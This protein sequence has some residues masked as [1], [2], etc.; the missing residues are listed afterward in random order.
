M[1]S[2]V[3][4]LCYSL[5]QLVNSDC[6]VITASDGSQYPNINQ[7]GTV[8]GNDPNDPAHWDFSVN[9]CTP[10]GTSCDSCGT[11]SGYCQQ[12]PDKKFSFCIGALNSVSITGKPGGAGLVAN[13]QATG[14]DQQTRKGVVTV[15]CNPNAQNPDNKAFVAPQNVNGYAASFDSAFACG[16]AGGLSGGSVFL[17]ILF[18]GFA[19]Y[20][21]GGMVFLA[22]VKGQ[23]GREMVPNLGFWM[24]IPG[25]IQDGAT[26]TVKRIKV[27]AGKE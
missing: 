27:L 17:I 22:G 23:R 6:G 14:N 9:L 21:I 13:F 7:I 5:I 19:A 26:F 20:F 2:V 15:N 10:L 1:I 12:S 11:G 25:L 4:F 24:M 8:V 18:A 3:I 16:T